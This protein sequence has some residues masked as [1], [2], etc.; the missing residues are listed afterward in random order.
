MPDRIDFVKEEDARRIA[1]GCFEE[2][3]ELL[4]G[5][6]KPHIE[7][8]VKA[9]GD[10]LCPELPGNGSSQERLAAARGSPKEKA[11]S[12]VSSIGM[13]QFGIAEGSQE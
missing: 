13:P 1:S 5:V 7:D 4:L 3:V 12:D 6:A 9:H 8:L 2:F 10:E 11:A